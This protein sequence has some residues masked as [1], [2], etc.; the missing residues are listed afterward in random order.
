MASIQGT[1]NM[2]SHQQTTT[3]NTINAEP[4]K[5]FFVEMLTRDI[6]LTDAILDLLDNCVDGALRTN[7][8]RGG[9]LDPNR[10]FEGFCA[11]ITIEKDLFSITDN[12]GGIPPKV[13]REYAFRFGRPDADADQ[14]AGLPTV[15]VYGIGMKRAL[16]KL[17]Q[18]A[19]VQSNRK[20][21]GAFSVHINADW[22]AS[23]SWQL[24]MDT[25][26]TPAEQ[27]GVSIEVR[28]L[29]KSVSIQ[30]DPATGSFHNHL[31]SKIRDHYAYIIQ[32]G[33]DVKV[34]GVS[35]TPALLQTLISERPGEGS[36][37]DPYI[38]KTEHDGVDVMLV[39]GMYERFPTETDLEEFAEGGRRKN[40]A[41]WTV[42]CNDRVVVSHDTSHITGWGEAGVPAYHS[43]FITLAGV[44]IF[45]CTEAAK[46]PLTTTKRGLDLSSP[47]YASVKEEMR[48]A[49]KHFTSFTY[50]WKSQTDERTNIQESAKAIDIRQAS[51]S[52]PADRWQESRKGLKGQRFVPQLP[53]PAEE[54]THSRISFEKAK[55]DISSLAEFMEMGSSARPSDVGSAAFDL[56]LAQARG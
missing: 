47:L 32:K 48:L 29:H 4:A 34:N 45:S 8:G 37:I 18:D 41:G 55:R 9:A 54:K 44:V 7:A 26:L 16:F 17:G 30:F 36:N 27:D 38:Y 40:T 35:V 2:T 46:L 25:L 13:A 3:S 12:C 1:N 31:H 33:M 19:R 21:D 15:G 11:E 52:V 42:I 6:E 43:Q 51:N 50:Q 23:D 22:L 53:K 56:L 49:L 28:S 20:N 39:M 24:E 5:R 10:P 14:D